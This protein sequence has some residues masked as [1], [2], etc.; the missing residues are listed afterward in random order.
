MK[1]LIV[2]TQGNGDIHLLQIQPG[3]LTDVMM[4]LD[5]LLKSVHRDTRKVMGCKSGQMDL[6]TK[7]C[8]LEIKHLDMADSSTLPEM[9]MKEIGSKTK[10]KAKVY[11]NTLMAQVTTESGIWIS[12]M[13]KA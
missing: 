6:S 5:L 2:F 12:N 13:V 3:K 9:F 11:S 1:K 10:H 7:V 8:G 4:I